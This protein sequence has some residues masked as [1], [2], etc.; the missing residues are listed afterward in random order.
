MQVGSNRVIINAAMA[1]QFWPDQDPIG[2]HFKSGDQTVEVVGV[3]KTG[4]YR[5]LSEDPQP[6]LYQPFGYS[7]Q[8]T[9]V[10]RSRED[11]QALFST[12][13]QQVRRLDPN[14]VPVDLETIAQFMALPLFPAHT[15]GVL[16][17]AFGAVALLLA[18]TGLYGVISYSVTR[19][20]GEIGIRMA[21][22]ANR[23]KVMSL[24]LGQGMRLSLIGIV[25][26][27]LISFAVTRV[28]SDLL[29]GIRPSDPFTFLAVTLFLV[30]VA[31]AACLLPA[32]R[33]ASIEPMQSLRTE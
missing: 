30:A 7:P 23:Y 3:V 4:K 18:M 24:I 11:S 5:A 2:R 13:R 25:T 17:S 29:Y 26:G 22:G 19:R 16:L 28:L 14:A 21:L 33:A 1:R 32:S 6:F 27:L 12:I 10:V 15:T 8:A 9:L 20:T 31:V